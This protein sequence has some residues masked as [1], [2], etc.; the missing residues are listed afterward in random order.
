MMKFTLVAFL[1]LLQ[2]GNLLAQDFN[3]KSNFR[4]FSAGIIVSPDLNGIHLS[5][6]AVENPFGV[7]RGNMPYEKW[8]IGFTAGVNGV[9]NFHKNWGLEIGI[10]YAKRSYAHNYEFI[11]GSRVDPMI[12][13]RME[14]VTHYNMIDI[15]I[16]INY[17]LGNGKLKLLT[18][19][20]IVVN[21]TASITNTSNLIYINDSISRSEVNS[22]VSQRFNISALAGLGIHWQYNE[23]NAL[24]IEPN[25][26]VALPVS[27]IY[28]DKQHFYTVGLHIGWYRSF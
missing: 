6:S 21:T 5:E 10:Q 16:R 4:K 13:K 22:T 8:N 25:L 9:W 17:T 14:S 7:P 20:G 1:T 28:N 11:V 23:S 2:I 18:S 26:R 3:H 27:T 24:R 19:M 15:P 12:P